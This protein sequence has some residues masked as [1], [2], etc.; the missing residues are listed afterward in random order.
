[1]PKPAADAVVD[2]VTVAYINRNVAPAIDS[3]TVQDPAVVFINGSYPASPQ[4]VE[5]T[6]PDEYG[7][8]TSLD[9]PRDRNEQGKKVYRKGFR[10][11]SWRA[12]DDNG[13]SLRYAISFRRSGSDK[14]LRLRDNV[15]ETSINF[16]T[17][18]LPDGSYELRLVATDAQDNPDMPLTDS[19]EAIEFR[20]DNT[21]P[22]ITAATDGDDVLV[23]VSDKVS[24]IGKVEYSADAQKWIRINPV[25]GIS[26]SPNETY[27]IKRSAL[28]G[29]FVIVRAVDAFYNVATESIPVP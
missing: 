4:V 20:V 16:D 17:S 2:G 27:R 25:D 19:K 23:R 28:A 15:E 22:S 8:F 5:A 21:A 12:H 24:P 1:M 13:D 18:Q 3:V 29:K 6:N 9:T 10:T 26:D 14:W 7:I 11:V